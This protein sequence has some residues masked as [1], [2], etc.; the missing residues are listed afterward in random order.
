MPNHRT[1]Y[2]MPRRVKAAAALLAIGVAV[3]GVG[4]AQETGIRPLS[5]SFTVT[6]PVSLNGVGNAAGRIV[7]DPSKH[8]LAPWAAAGMRWG[9]L[10]EPDARPIGELGLRFRRRAVRLALG[11]SRDVVY[12][13]VSRSRQPTSVP[14]PQRP[15]SLT[16]CNSLVCETPFGVNADTG[17]TTAPHSGYTMHPVT[18]VVASA[19]WSTGPVAFGMESGWRLAGPRRGRP[20]LSATLAA[21]LVATLAV[22]AGLDQQR[23]Q[24]FSRD[25][26]RWTLGFQWR[27]SPWRRRPKA[28]SRPAH[29]DSA[30]QARSA[31]ESGFSVQRQS[32]GVRLRLLAPAAEKV[33]VRSDLT[34]WTPAS[35]LRAADGAWHIDLTAAAGV[36][37]V[38]IRIDN[39]PWLPPPGLAV[40]SDGY[41]SVVGLLVIDP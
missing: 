25:G 10:F 7:L 5:G 33:E 20:W 22:V 17:Q 12:G 2:S 14:Q 21:P 36:H 19:E 29:A 27:S 32:E 16:I 37:R 28:Q 4:H 38:A 34:Q 41:G 30:A 9:G 26:T 11:L 24:V 40:G 39:G 3:G 13:T 23:D 31:S 35:L 18:D 8:S 6:Q 15:E 1:G